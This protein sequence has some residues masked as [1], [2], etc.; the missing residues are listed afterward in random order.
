MLRHDILKKL[1]PFG[2]AIGLATSA[3][4]GQVQ[5]KSLNGDTS[6]SG[7]LIDYD[8]QNYTIRT[9]VGDL[10]IDAIQ[11]SC[12]GADC[13]T[14][15]SEPGSFGISGSTT[16]VGKLFT[17][18]LF[19]FGIDIGGDTLTSLTPD[20]PTKVDVRNELGDTLA[21]ISLNAQ[22]SVQGLRD[23]YSGAADL[24]VMTRPVSQEENS[25]F[26]ISGKGDLTDPAHQKIFALDGLVVI[27]SKNNPIRAVSEQ[28][29]PKIFSGQLTNWA[30]IGG[31]NANINLYVRDA[32]SG[33]GVV[34]NDL[35]MGPAGA[36][37]STEA[38]VLETDADVAKAVA[39][40]P[41]GVGITSLA[42]VDN[43]KVM[44]IRGTCGIQVPATPFTIKTEEYPLTRR[45]YTYTVGQDTPAQ[46]S[47]FLDFLGSN[48]AQASIARNGFVDLGVS[49]QSNDE[50]GLRY[51]S[52]VIPTDVEMTL[53]QLRDMTAALLASDRL[54]IT[55]RFALGSSQLDV[56]AKDDIQR[57]ADILATGDFEN[58]ELLLIGYTDSIGAGGANTNLSLQR[59]NEVQAALTSILP[60]GSVSGLPIQTLGFGEISPL[61]CNDS[62]NGRR[63]NR[64]VEVW[65]RDA[66]TISR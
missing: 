33:T 3:M 48:A 23:I 49:F 47:R 28:D 36:Q 10:V 62:P 38:V 52:A 27:T 55:F 6:L 50:Q 15:T 32:T 64:R 14:V 1:V 56:R 59:A 42:D 4:A 35:V 21:N 17:D 5:L 57:L 51:L 2:L 43:A 22:G 8:G 26:A 12:V 30:Q 7:D 11:V 40:D 45:L 19:E 31:P 37:I 63:I 39:T 24:A 46:L 54:S 61:A 58:K 66:V 44:A 53:P 20:G 25:I 29:L 65:L 9:I 16:A 60:G 18:L 13:P 41:L 34:F